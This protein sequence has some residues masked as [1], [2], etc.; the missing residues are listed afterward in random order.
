[1]LMFS[2]TIWNIF[3]NRTPLVAASVSKTHPKKQKYRYSTNIF[4]ETQ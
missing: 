1:M 3:K 4:A 2:C